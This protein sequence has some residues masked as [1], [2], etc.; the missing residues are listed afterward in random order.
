MPASCLGLLTGSIPRVTCQFSIICMC[1]LHVQTLIIYP[2][3]PPFDDSDQAGNLK[4]LLNAKVYSTMPVSKMAGNVGVTFGCYNSL[5]GISQ[6]AAP[7][8]PSPVAAAKPDLESGSSSA[9]GE[10]PPTPTAASQAA[11]KISTYAFRVKGQAKVDTLFSMLEQVK[12]QS[13]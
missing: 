3:A 2:P 13:A 6:E 12:A 5:P 9:A 8:S 7:P 11:V 1:D 10:A 4:L